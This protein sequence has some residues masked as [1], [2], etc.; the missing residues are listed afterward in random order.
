METSATTLQIQGPVVVV[1]LKEYLEQKSQLEEY[2]R[3]KASYE[4]E[5]EERFRRLL[6]IAERN[7]AMSLEQVEV[8]VE[9]AVRAARDQA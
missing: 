5:R 8:D 6:A 9:A 4:Q 1:P 2:R 7:R 3:L